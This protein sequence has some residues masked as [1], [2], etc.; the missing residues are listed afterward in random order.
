MKKIT[1]LFTLLV[2]S[3]FGQAQCTATGTNFGNNTSNTMYNVQGTVNVVLNTNNTISLSTGSNFSTAAGPD[4]RVYIL[5]RGTLTDAQ[6]KNTINFP[7]LPKIEMGLISGNGAMSFTKNIP[8]SVTISDFDT[9]YF[10]CEDFNLF[11]DFGNYVPFTTSNCSV[12]SSTIFNSD[13]FTVYPNPMNDVFSVEVGNN[14]KIETITVYN[15]LGQVV[16]VKNENMEEVTD[17]SNLKQGVYYLEI[18]D[19]EGNTSIKNIVKRI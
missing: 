11:W 15:S 2:A 18:L 7:S 6:L 17:V 8:N 4:V 5:D 16:L 14:V 12:L 10:L 1:Y 9:I 13:N 19:I 3:Y